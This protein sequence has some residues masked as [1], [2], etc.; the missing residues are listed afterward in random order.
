MKLNPIRVQIPTEKPEE[1]TSGFTEV[2]HPYT[3]EDAV[4][5]A[6]RC[7]QCGRPYCVEACP[8]T[9]DAR[10]YIRL[11]A[12]R[13][14]DESARSILSEDP[15]A[16]TLCKVCYHYCEDACIVAKK[17]IPVAIRHLKRAGLEF[18]NSNLLY[19]PSSPKRQRVAVIGAGPAGIMAA[20]ELGLRGYSVTVFEQEAYLGGQAKT[21]PKYRMYG[22]EVKVDTARF[23]NL[24]VKFEEKTKIGVDKPV[25]SLLGHGYEAVYLSIGTSLPRTLDVPGEDLP[26]VIPA[27]D[28][29]KDVNEGA[30]PTLGKN[31]VVVGGGDV[32]MD[33][34]RSAPRLSP[35]AQVTLVYRRTRDEM[36]ADKDERHEAEEEK[37]RFIFLASPVRVVGT[38]RVEG[39][40]VQKMDLGP[41]DSSGRRSPVPVPG[42]NY[43]IPCDTL[44]VAVGQKADLRGFPKELELK[45][46]SQGWPQGKRTDMMTEVEGIFASGGRS[47]VYAMA[48]GTKAAE[49]IDAY[50]AKKR[51]AEPSIRPD[52]WGGSMPPAKL[53]KG[54]TKQV[55]TL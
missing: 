51:G 46:G 37:I 29:L 18:G 13:K 25:E 54:Y 21:I 26:G 34:V 47:V 23:K 17:G 6:K 42:S 44:I 31:I 36:P 49:S 41:P 3:L 11:I 35:G 10:E 45:L 16:T 27:L 52:P 8:I 43:V 15:L 32:A 28:M 50:L 7:I 38:F 4:L 14:F 30:V 55:W 1:R 24:D 22:D 48:A 2:L 5:E 12:E 20:W 40:E 19:V 53:P 9:Q 33:A 39:V